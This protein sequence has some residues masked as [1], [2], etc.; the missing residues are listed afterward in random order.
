MCLY[1]VHPAQL[2]SPTGY[3][4]STTCEHTS[5]IAQTVV[6]TL[7]TENHMLKLHHFYYNHIFVYFHTKHENVH[8][9]EKVVVNSSSSTAKQYNRKNAVDIM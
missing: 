6:L 9:Q 8:K 4:Y 2:L 5:R 3:R 7:T 1:P